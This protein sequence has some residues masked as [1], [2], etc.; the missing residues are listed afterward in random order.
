MK[1]GD[2]DLEPELRAAGVNTALLKSRADRTLS[3]QAKR[4]TMPRN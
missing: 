3:C 1:G 2:G 4:E